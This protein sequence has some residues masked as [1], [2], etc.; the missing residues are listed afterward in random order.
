MWKMTYPMYKSIFKEKTHFVLFANVI[1]LFSLSNQFFM[2]TC[3]QNFVASIRNWIEKCK[4]SY[5]FKK[6]AVTSIFCMYFGWRTFYLCSLLILN[7]V[8]EQSKQSFYRFDI[9]FTLEWL[10]KT[11]TIKF[12]FHFPAQ[13]N[14]IEEKISYYIIVKHDYSS[15]PKSVSEIHTKLENIYDLKQLVNLLLLI[16]S[17]EFYILILQAA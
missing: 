3:D 13:V 6:N 1:N 7:W 4:V 8:R 10:Y 15:W 9:S 16:R 5:L 17:V 14:S 2:S 11:G 12:F